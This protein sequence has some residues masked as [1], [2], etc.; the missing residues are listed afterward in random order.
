MVKPK[1]HNPRRPSSPH[2]GGV[3]PGPA[4]RPS[5]SGGGTRHRPPSLPSSGSDKPP[6]S[7]GCCPMVA[8]IKAIRHG[9]FRLGRRYLKWSFWIIVDKATP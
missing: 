2:P 3:G 9:K 5:S 8:G 6:K 7:T 4:Y 1:P